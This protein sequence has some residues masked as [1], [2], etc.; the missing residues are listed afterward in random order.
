LKNRNIDPQDDFDDK[1]RRQRQWFT[2]EE[3]QRMLVPHKPTHLRYLAAMRA[4][5]D[6]ANPDTVQVMVCLHEP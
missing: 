2:V 6:A 5:R 1:D 3:A 4:T